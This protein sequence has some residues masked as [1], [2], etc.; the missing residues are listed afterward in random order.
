MPKHN[1]FAY[2]IVLIAFSFLFLQCPAPDPT[3]NFTLIRLFK[4]GQTTSSQAGD[5]G[6]LEPGAAW[7]GTRFTVDT[8]NT[9]LDNLTGLIWETAPDAAGYD[10]A[11]ALTLADGST[12]GGYTDWRLP[13]INELESMSNSEWVSHASWLNSNGFTGVYNGPHW[14]STTDGNTTANAWY[15]DFANGETETGA[16]TLNTRRVFLVRGTTS[17]L[18]K[19]GQTISYA[20]GD[21]GDLETGAAWP[22][23]RFVDNG[24]TITDRLTGL[25][26]EKDP[27]NTKRNWAD[28]LTLVDG[29]TTGGY[30]DWRLPS[31]RELRSLL[32]YTYGGSGIQTRL[33]A[34]GFVVFAGNYWTSTTFDVGTPTEAYSLAFTSGSMVR[35]S[36][37]NDP[38]AIA[39]R[40]WN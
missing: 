22:V 39:V 35:S 10:W 24:T 34:V 36:K 38:W 9:M 30:T 1:P 2:I 25:V 18:A 40:G 21:D 5:D 7:P 20:A 6:D 29:L 27:D 16:K 19:T 32:D 33:T 17:L 23:T 3:D 28:A 12:V 26:W 14:T 11:G 15:F 4:T 8:A 37:A 31:K 13:N